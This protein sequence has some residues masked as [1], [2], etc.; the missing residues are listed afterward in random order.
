MMLRAMQSYCHAKRGHV[1]AFRKTG[2]KCTHIAAPPAP[3]PKPWRGGTDEEVLR[4]QL[5]LLAGLAEHE[6]GG[7]GNDAAHDQVEVDARATRGRE[8][9]ELLVD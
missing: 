2:E 1:E 6:R 7:A 9:A 5:L 4:E 3:R 8:D